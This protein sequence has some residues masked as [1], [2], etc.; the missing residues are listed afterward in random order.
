MTRQT[1]YNETL[2]RQSQDKLEH[3]TLTRMWTRYEPQ[4]QNKTGPFKFTCDT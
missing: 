1:A 3:K 2:D 4:G